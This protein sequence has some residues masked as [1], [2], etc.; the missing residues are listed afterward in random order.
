[1]NRQKKI[2]SFK[3]NHSL[4]VLSRKISSRAKIKINIDAVTAAG[5]P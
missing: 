4:P 3:D 1:M 2:I 5:R